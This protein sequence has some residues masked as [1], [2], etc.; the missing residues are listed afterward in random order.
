MIGDF[1]GAFHKIDDL[2]GSGGLAVASGLQEYV[3]KLR[4][5]SALDTLHEGFLDLCVKRNLTLR[6]FA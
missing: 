4:N 6:S 2:L 1:A 3:G 5:R